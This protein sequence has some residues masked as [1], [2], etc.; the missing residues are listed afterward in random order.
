MTGAVRASREYLAIARHYD[1]RSAQRSGVPL[2][3]HIDHGLT[4]L[5]RIG[6]SEIAMRA[7]CLHP[8]VQADDEL[9]ARFARL[10]ELT[11]DPRVAALA[12][13]Y[14][15]VANA[16]LSTRELASVEAI[17]LSPLPEVNA[18]LV[19]DKVQ[20]RRDFER[21][22]RETHRRAAELERYFARWLERL[23][24]DETTYAQLIADL[25]GG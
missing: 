22:H 10:D 7:Y 20:N 14:R 15:H 6:A 1:T 25:D 5:A 24:I 2:M 19:A 3:Q 9:R 11:D 21:H 4:I 18:M 16:A 8:L 12:I 17:A 13:E 23:G